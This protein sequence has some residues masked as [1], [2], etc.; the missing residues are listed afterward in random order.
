MRPFV[1]LLSFVFGAGIAL[2]HGGGL[3]ANGCHDDRQDGGYHCHGGLLSGR[4]FFSRAD[5]ELALE[6][7]R[8]AVS[9]PYLQVPGLEPEPVPYDRAL[10]RHWIDSDGDCQDTRQEVLIAESLVEPEIEGCRVVS[11]LWFDPFTGATFSD[12]SALEVDHFIPLAEVHRSGGDRWTPELRQRYANDLF[13]TR[14]LIV[15]S[16]SANRSAGDRDPAGWLPRNE[17]YR[18]EYVR[19]W[20]ILK[21][22]WG[23]DMDEAE[24]EAV[25][26]VLE[27]CP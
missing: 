6:R 25:R 1:A 14:S 4:I 24:A 11:G 16:V 8:P 21:A 12:P 15:V 17:A 9:T 23:L 18:C 20:V 7:V 19:T 22:G 27:K 10:Y 26:N 2:A 5:A 13:H 3:D